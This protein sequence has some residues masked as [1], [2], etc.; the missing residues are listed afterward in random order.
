M[1]T[2]RILA[3]WALWLLIVQAGIHLGAPLWM[4]FVLLAPWALSLWCLNE[5]WRRWQSRR[6][7]E[8]HLSSLNLGHTSASL[9][10]PGTAHRMRADRW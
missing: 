3:A 9:R 10:G 8:R 4:L 5:T 6:R 7:Q 1:R 2:I